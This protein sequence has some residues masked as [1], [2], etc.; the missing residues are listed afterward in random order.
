MAI[1]G[2]KPGQLDLPNFDVRKRLSFR[3]IKD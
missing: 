1:D 3:E 2:V